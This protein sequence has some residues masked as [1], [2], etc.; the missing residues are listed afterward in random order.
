MATQT[1]T[2]QTQILKSLQ[3]NDSIPLPEYNTVVTLENDLNYLRSVIRQMK[4]TVD[5]NSPVLHTLEDLANNMASLLDG[6]T[7]NNITLTGSVTAP[8]VLPANSSDTVATTQFVHNALAAAGATGD[9]H[10]AIPKGTVSTDPWTITHGMGKHPA[11]VFV[12]SGGKE[13]E[14]SVEYLNL[15]ELTVYFSRPASGTLYLN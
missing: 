13:R 3:I 14:V 10:L 15:N 4:G 6:A 2:R 1:R 8:T 12:N 7:L 9:K 5:Y 11:V